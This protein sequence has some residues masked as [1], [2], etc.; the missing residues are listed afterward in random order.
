[1]KRILLFIAPVFILLTSSVYA[2]TESVKVGIVNIDMVLQQSP[3]AMSYNEKISK[4][5]KPRQE[6]LN[7]AQKKLQVSLD[8]LTYNGFQMSVDE[9][10][11]LRNSINEEKREFDTLNAS[12]QQDLQTMQNK[13]TQEL[14][15][16]LGDVIKAIATTGKYDIVQTNANI[17]YLDNSV[18]ITPDVIKQLK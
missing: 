8:K 15:G 4:E 18:D 16:K 14:L 1:M 2:A 13:Y 6:K 5:F 12:L 11:K 17:L 7:D 10:N 3:L 9:R